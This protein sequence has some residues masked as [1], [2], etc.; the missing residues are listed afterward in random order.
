M[1]DEKLSGAFGIGPDDIAAN[2]AGRL[3]PR[4][5][6]N[7]K[8]SGYNN[9]IL[10]F[11]AGGILLA[12]LL[13]VANK[14][15]KPAQWITAGLLFAALLATGV[16]HFR[17]THAAAA[18]GVVERLSG[19]VE[20]ISRGRS[21]FFLEVGGRSFRMP[22]RPWHVKSGNSYHVYVAP[23]VNQVVGMEPDAPAG[24]SSA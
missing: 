3:G 19:V 23:G 9:V 7:L 2:R 13:G 20:V 21:G 16:Y 10:A 18:A 12:I 4:Q 15:L 17:K 24:V 11:V 6:H 1:S 8:R 22:V 5:A 14:P